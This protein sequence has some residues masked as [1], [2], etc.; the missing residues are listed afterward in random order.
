MVRIDPRAFDLN[1]RGQIFFKLVEF[2]FQ[3][4]DLFVQ[5]I[6]DRWLRK[7]DVPPDRL[8]NI[9]AVSELIL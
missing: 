4:A 9:T 7:R 6:D 3:L 2:H 5:L 1:R 8:L